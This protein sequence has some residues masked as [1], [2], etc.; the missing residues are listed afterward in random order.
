M[1]PGATIFADR[2]IFTSV[3]GSVRQLSALC[4]LWRPPILSEHHNLYT[5]QVRYSLRSTP[6]CDTSYSCLHIPF[7]PTADVATLE[8]SALSRVEVVSPD[9][10]PVPGAASSTAVSSA[11]VPVGGASTA[12]LPSSTEV[13]ESYVASA[14]QAGEPEGHREATTAAPLAAEVTASSAVPSVDVPVQS[15][16][17]TLPMSAQCAPPTAS[18]QT[19]LPTMETSAASV[20][21][22]ACA[23]DMDVPLRPE[24][25]QPVPRTSPAVKVS[26]SGDSGGF[27]ASAPLAF[28]SAVAAPVAP[29]VIVQIYSGPNPKGKLI[30]EFAKIGWTLARA[31]QFTTTVAAPFVSTLNI[32]CPQGNIALKGP[33][34]TTKKAAEQAA[35]AVAL[36][37]ERVL[38]LLRPPVPSTVP[39]SAV[40]HSPVEVVPVAPQQQSDRDGGAPASVAVVGVE[41]Q[42]ALSVTGDTASDVPGSTESSTPVAISQRAEGAVSEHAVV[43]SPLNTSSPAAPVFPAAGHVA[44]DSSN[45]SCAVMASVGAIAADNS[46]VSLS[47]PQPA[48]DPG[49]AAVAASTLPAVVPASAPAPS[50]LP[51]A[52][53]TAAAA[54]FDFGPNPK[55]KLLEDFAKIGRTGLLAPQFVTTTV[56]PFFTTVTVTGPQGNIQLVGPDQGTKKAAERAAAAVAL[57]DARVRQMLNS[58]ALTQ[59]PSPVPQSPV[60]TATLPSQQYPN[61][62][63]GALAAAVP[64]TMGVASSQPASVLNPLSPP[65]R[66]HEC[67]GAEPHALST[68][69]VAPTS[70]SVPSTVTPSAV[71]VNVCHAVPPPPHSEPDVAPTDVQQLSPLEPS[72]GA[73]SVQHAVAPPP[74]A[75]SAPIVLPG[76]V[77]PHDYKGELLGSCMRLNNIVQCEP[78]F[79]TTTAPPF[80]STFTLTPVGIQLTGP[81]AQNRKAAEQAVALMALRDVTARRLLRLPSLSADGSHTLMP[82]GTET[83]LASDMSSLTAVDMI[84]AEP[85]D[86]EPTS[87]DPDPAAPSERGTLLSSDSGGGQVIQPG[88]R[89]ESTA[90]AAPLQSSV[91]CRQCHHLLGDAAHFF[92]YTASETEAQLAVK[93]EVVGQLLGSIVASVTDA[94]DAGSEDAPASDAAVVEPQLVL[95]PIQPRGESPDSVPSS[96]AGTETPTSNS[97]SNKPEKQR[98]L[99]GNCSCGVGVK[100]NTGPHNAPLCSLGAEK[101]QINRIGVK[102]WKKALLDGLLSCFDRRNADT[103]YGTVT[104]AVSKPTRAINQDPVVFPVIIEGVGVEDCPDFQVQDLL[105]SHCIASGKVPRSEQLQAYHLALKSNLIVMF[106]TGHGKTFVASLVMH[107]FRKLNPSKLVVMVVDRVPLVQQQCEAIHCDTG[108]TVC[109][110][111]S[112]NSTQTVLKYLQ[113][114]KYDALV[115]TAGVLRNWLVKERRLNISDFSV[116]VMDECH[117]V[118]GNHDYS[119]ILAQVERTS[120][121]L[122]PR[123]VGL[124]ASPL[125]I[126]SKSESSAAEKLRQLTEAFLGADVYR[127]PGLSSAFAGIDFRK[128]QLSAAQ[129]AEQQRLMTLLPPKVADLLDLYRPHKPDLRDLLPKSLPKSTAS[130][131]QHRNYW[132]AAA[133]IASE[134]HHLSLPLEQSDPLVKTAVETRQLI[135]E[136]QSNFLLGPAF[137]HRGAGNSSS[138]VDAADSLPPTSDH[139]FPPEQLSSQLLELCRELDG[140]GETSKTLVFVPQRCTAESLYRYLQRRYPALNCAKL[141]G[142]GGW[143]GMKWR[144]LDGQGAVLD[145]FRRGETK[146]IVC[147]SVLEEGAL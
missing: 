39:P 50:T 44:L 143:D 118:G 48:A 68:S 109:P 78:K 55:G 72:I 14:A 106:P 74:Q 144:G 119:D 27:T 45:G 129:V 53:T 136:L 123:V 8:N 87:T 95:L 51:P 24:E 96:D 126:K 82:A 77:Q 124:S 70:G 28:P 101:V 139:L 138:D 67:G 56:A 16:Q 102:S 36:A 145:R 65:L 42:R 86:A 9:G 5:C 80:C 142:Q 30:E 132:S 33:D 131:E 117:H 100:M 46:P 69:A 89:L 11:G 94:V 25:P 71:P 97:A 37:D 112:E 114:G 34:C 90:P 31:P 17:T 108:M 6:V 103:F 3:Q 104:L 128:V 88:S 121:A 84:F 38:R 81:P 140:Y 19:T 58:P 83:E 61:G 29:Q 85:D 79:D 1:L 12:A 147:T 92:V 98:I 40:P 113:T 73:V 10:A 91:T 59:A 141:I 93:P 137:V 122:K 116:I 7:L 47:A 111:S 18:M 35:A 75:V 4:P 125:N 26:A 110:I 23:A 133:N 76:A 52:G 2:S 146:L 64:A 54:V 105:S 62:G 43:T 135:N 60:M 13:Q 22:D 134:N 32:T 49:G 20:D 120:H 15:A 41:Q 115:V 99:C 130:E 63:T 127:P 57:A 21:H 66:Q 107:R